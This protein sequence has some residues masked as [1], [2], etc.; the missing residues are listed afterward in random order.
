MRRLSVTL[1][2][3]G[4]F[5][6]VLALFLA[7]YAAP[8]LAKAPLDQSEQSESTGELTYFSIGDLEE[9]TG[10]VIS[11]RTVRGD[12]E[13]GNESVAVW[14]MFLSTT[15]AD[16]GN[17]LSVTQERIALDRSTA[18][19]VNCCGET[20]THEGLTLKFPFGT[21][22]VDYELWDST[23]QE[24]F[25]VRF[26]S[27]DEIDG[28]SVYRFVQEIGPITLGTRD[29]PASLIGE[30]GTGDVTA[31]DVYEVTKTLL[32]EPTT[33][34]IIQGDQV[35]DQRLELDDRRVLTISDGE[36]GYTDEQ[37]AAN[38]A[39]AEDDT[40]LL[41]LISTLLPI[42]GL[43][44]GALLIVA[45]LFLGVRRRRQPREVPVEWQEPTHV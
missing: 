17:V 2:S 18:E 40:R 25:P 39:T 38:V 24:A 19:S 29:V 32:V 21:D 45:G 10:E 26:E 12:V 30:E 44:L 31:D 34:R 28:L 13:A 27:V 11:L 9:K 8:R 3:V 20:P 35:V 16:T 14:D 36:V 4:V 23:A 43:V 42:A 15:E 22:Q 1:F 7:F 37:V 5:L 6:V 41:N 33:G